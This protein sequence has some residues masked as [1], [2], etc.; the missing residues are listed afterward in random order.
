MRVN[1]PAR[2]GDRDRDALRV[3]REP[4]RVPAGRGRARRTR[5]T[6]AVPRH[7]GRSRARGLHGRRA[8]GERAAP[9]RT[10][11]GEPSSSHGGTATSSCSPTAGAPPSARSRRAASIPSSSS[12]I[13]RSVI[14]GERAGI[15]VGRRRRD[16]VRSPPSRA[17]AAATTID[18]DAPAFLLAGDETAH[19]RDLRNCSKCSRPRLRCTSCSRSRTPTRA[20]HSRTTRTRGSSGTIS[21]RVRP[22]VT[23]SSR[24]CARRPSPPGRRS[25]RRAKPRRSS[26]SARTSST[27]S[28]SRVPQT[29]IR[30]YWK[31]GRAG[32]GES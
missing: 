19:P 29:T 17:P 30:G 7:P 9:F 24:P 11:H 1:G 12:S 5:H 21:R 20:S 2:D 26:A 23:G 10:E 14:H 8:R 31:H 22:P 3:R 18:G 16:P 25:G 6:A 27:S 4:P 28:R 15:G 32:A 13:S